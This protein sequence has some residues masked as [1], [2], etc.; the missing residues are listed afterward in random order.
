MLKILPRVEGIKYLYSE[1]KYFQTFN[2]TK[3][4]F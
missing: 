3:K 4:Q 1:K 2:F